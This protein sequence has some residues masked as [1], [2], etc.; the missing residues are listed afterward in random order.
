MLVNQVSKDQE[1][2][3]EKKEKARLAREHKAELKRIAMV[4]YVLPSEEDK[5]AEKAL[6]KIAT[7]GGLFFFPT[8]TYSNCPLQ[9][10]HT[11]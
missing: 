1:E 11:Q 6:K 2:L 10:N 4:G 3:K 9:C 5:E 7:K 8:I